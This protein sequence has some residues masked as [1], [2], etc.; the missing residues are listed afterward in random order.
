MKLLRLVADPLFALIRSW[1]AVDRIRASPSE[2]RLLG[3][4]NGQTILIRGEPALVRSC[5]MRISNNDACLEY[6]LDYIGA[7]CTLTVPVPDT[8]RSISGQIACGDQVIPVFDDDIV[9]LTFEA[10]FRAAFVNSNH[11]HPDGRSS[12]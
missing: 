6:S 2:G 4:R 3:L 1:Y 9:M 7:H 5:T 12:A 10:A 11:S 8:T